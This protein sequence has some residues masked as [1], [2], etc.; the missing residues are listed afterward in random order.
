[1]PGALGGEGEHMSA[2]SQLYARCPVRPDPRSSKDGF[3]VRSI[4]DAGCQVASG[5]PTST[6]NWLWTGWMLRAHLIGLAT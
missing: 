1:M 6:W 4:A 5:K 2:G 3:K